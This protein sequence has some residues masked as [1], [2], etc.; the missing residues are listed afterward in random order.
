MRVRGIFS[1]LLAGM[2]NA[3]Q[4]IARVLY[5][6]WKP[7]TIERWRTTGSNPKNIQRCQC[8]TFG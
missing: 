6:R 7:V 8:H 3:Y 1:P 2:E 4:M 5:N